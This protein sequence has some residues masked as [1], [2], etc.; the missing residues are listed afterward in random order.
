MKS[1]W[2]TYG[3]LSACLLGLGACNDQLTDY[4]SEIQQT[5]NVRVQLRTGNDD[6]CASKQTRALMVEFGQSTA[7]QQ[8]AYKAALGNYREIEINPTF[9]AKDPVSENWATMKLLRTVCNGGGQSDCQ[10]VTVAEKLVRDER[11]KPIEG[12]TT[13]VKKTDVLSITSTTI[14]DT[15]TQ[16]IYSTQDRGTFE[17]ISTVADPTFQPALSA[18]HLQQSSLNHYDHHCG[19]FVKLQDLI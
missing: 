3:L 2:K 11:V 14:L 4:A 16:L 18:G 8:T 19:Q 12:A 9:S 1:T 7:A 6:V 5:L 13:E 17:S 10:D 15:S